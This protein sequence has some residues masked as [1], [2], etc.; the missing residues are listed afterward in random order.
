MSI[1]LDQLERLRLGGRSLLD[2]ARVEQARARCVTLS[3]HVGRLEEVRRPAGEGGEEIP[4]P[5]HGQGEE[6]ALRL[7]YDHFPRLRP[8]VPLLVRLWSIAS[9]DPREPEEDLD[10][11]SELVEWANWELEY[12]RTPPALVI[13]TALAE[14]VTLAP[15][16]RGNSL[17]AKLWGTLMMLRS[18]FE[19]VPLVPL[20][21][22]VRERA[23]R[24]RACRDRLRA[25]KTLRALEYWSEVILECMA[26]QGE[27]A[28]E[29]QEE[30][31]QGPPLPALQETLVNLARQ[32]GQLT[33]RRAREVTQASR[34]TLKD[35]FRRLV[36]N[37]YLVRHGQRRGV[38]YTPAR[39]E[40]TRGSAG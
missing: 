4:F 39:Q 2:F 15:F 10:A 34:N 28:L 12:A 30:R 27:L 37:G 3:D 21:E 9:S 26:V 5:S 29:R 17:L 11:L 23:T 24:L 13:S 14:L 22:V 25:E 31:L 38:F 33:S 7:L 35:N 8:D 18:G 16:P 19:Y 1:F 32:E 40:E 20:E 36:Q 6:A